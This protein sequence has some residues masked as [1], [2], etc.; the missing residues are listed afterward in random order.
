MSQV[1]NAPAV[2]AELSVVGRNPE[3]VVRFPRRVLLAPMEGV[4]DQLFRDLVIDLGWRGRRLQR[5]H[6]HLELSNVGAG[7]PPLSRSARTGRC[8]WV[9]SSWP[10]NRPSSPKASSPQSAS[11]RCGSIS[12]SA[13]RHRSSSA[14]ARV[15]PCSRSPEKIA[16]HH[17]HRGCRGER[18][19]ERQD[20]R[21]HR[22]CRPGSTRSCKRSARRARPCSPC[23]RACAASRTAIRRPGSWIAQAKRTA[24]SLRPAGTGGRQRRGGVRRRRRAHDRRDRLRRGDG[25]RGAP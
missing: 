13:A 15:P 17:P 2:S 14:N 24:R 7:H 20:P 10:V 1:L 25:R 9:C 22:G 23:M 19:G 4:T 8:R 6:P 21:R 11:G 3:R 5:V 16:R 18:A 12:T